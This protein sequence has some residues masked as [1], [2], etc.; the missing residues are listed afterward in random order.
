MLANRLFQ[1]LL[2]PDKCRMKLT[3]VEEPNVSTDIRLYLLPGGANPI[4]NE[5]VLQ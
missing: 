4:M 2:C 3:I 5:F 1:Q